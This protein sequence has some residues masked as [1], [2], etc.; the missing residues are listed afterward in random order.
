[1]FKQ[2]LNDNRAGL[3][4]HVK[5]IVREILKQIQ[6]HILLFNPIYKRTKELNPGGKMKEDI[7]EDAMNDYLEQ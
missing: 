1:M 6:T 3:D 2:Q 7:C 4:N 5:H